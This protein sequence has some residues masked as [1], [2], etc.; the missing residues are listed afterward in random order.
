M[1]HC[2]FQTPF[3]RPL[4]ILLF[5]CLPQEKRLRD[6]QT[7]TEESLQKRLDAARTDMELSKFLSPCVSSEKEKKQ[8]L[9]QLLW[10]V[11]KEPGVFDVVIINDDLERA[12]DELKAIL[13]EVST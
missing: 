3:L 9:T 2:A 5:N 4:R 1:V 13:N 10:S 11:G 8:P 12:Y 6:R 7:E